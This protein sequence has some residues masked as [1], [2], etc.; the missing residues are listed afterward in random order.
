MQDRGGQIAAVAIT[1]LIL[2][3][4]TVGL[5]C[6]VRTFLVKGFGL[7]DKMMIVTLAF[8]T[9]YLACQIGGA[10]HG[11]GAHRENLT[12]EQAQTALHYWFFCE[13]FYTISTSIFKIA[14]GLFLLRITVAPL[15]IWII[16]FIMAVSAVVGASYTLLVL[17]QCRPMS[18]W[19][20]LNPDHTGTCIP[21]TLVMYLTY[22]VSALNS[23]ADWTFGI[24]PIFVVKDLQMKRR[25][26]VIVS[27]I[28]GLAAIGSTATIIRLPYTSSLGQYKGDFLY[29]T[30]DF[31]IWTTVEVGIGITAGCI[32]TL[33][34]LF[35]AVLGS[36]GQN[37][38]MP[39]SKGPAG[40]QSKIGGSF[41]TQQA[42]EDLRPAGE[43]TI[44]TTTVTGGRGSSSDEENFLDTG[45][46]EERWEGIRK[47]VTTTVTSIE[48]KPEKT[49]AKVSGDYTHGMPKADKRR[50][51]SL[52]QRSNST[53]DEGER[54]P[55]GTF[56][57]FQ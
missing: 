41:G 38:G 45:A 21:A 51:L 22:A 33:K 27:G 37:S 29:R 54:K 3:W 25:V 7:D 34:P 4:V 44:R 11:S 48:V 31:A 32:A 23:V 10:V 50:S 8:F 24:L 35:K 46:P 43:R 30:T 26:K 9:A 17:L 40:F 55:V 52:G 28:I 20:D 18:F 42:L 56:N 19:W 16:W 15:H 2:S 36:T 6:Y 53:L 39:W 13:V 49:G 57:P 1:F 14:I 47:G 12:D 5:R